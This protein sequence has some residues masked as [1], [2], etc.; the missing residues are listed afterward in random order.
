M[1]PRGW[2]LSCGTLSA[3]I[4]CLMYTVA[5]DFFFVGIHQTEHL[6]SHGLRPVSQSVSQS[7]HH[8]ILNCKG[9]ER[10][11]G[12]N[13]L[14]KDTWDPS[15]NVLKEKCSIIKKGNGSHYTLSSLKISL[16]HIFDHPVQEEHHQQQTKSHHLQKRLRGNKG[17]GEGSLC[18]LGSWTF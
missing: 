13:S 3:D 8:C 16:A 11:S 10:K 14:I 2:N 12:K 1:R 18:A 4:S 15:L 6:L 5:Y 7:G 9:K 17:N